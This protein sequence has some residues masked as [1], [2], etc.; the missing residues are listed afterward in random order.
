MNKYLSACTWGQNQVLCVPR[1]VCYQQGHYGTFKAN[2]TPTFTKC[3]SELKYMYMPKSFK[4]W[5][6]S[7]VKVSL[8]K[9]CVLII[10]LQNTGRRSAF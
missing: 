8:N 3:A 2:I 7:P 1:Q 9:D 10:L 6:N 4:F 5:V